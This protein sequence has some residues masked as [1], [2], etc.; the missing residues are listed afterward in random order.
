MTYFTDSARAKICSYTRKHFRSPKIVEFGTHVD[1]IAC[2]LPD[3]NKPGDI[4][5]NPA[6]ALEGEMVKISKND[7]FSYFFQ[8]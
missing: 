1:L 8:F 7:N 5:R 6:G 4:L 3:I 2:T